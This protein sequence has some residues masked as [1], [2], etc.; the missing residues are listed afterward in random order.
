MCNMKMR[1]VHQMCHDLSQSCL[2]TVLFVTVLI[3]LTIGYTL[4]IIFTCW[5]IP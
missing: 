2:K 5:Q 4:I 3:Y 1:L